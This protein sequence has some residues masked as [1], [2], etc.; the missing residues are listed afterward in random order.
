MRREQ[1]SDCFDPDTSALMRPPSVLT[2]RVALSVAGFA[3]ERSRRARIAKGDGARA[4]GFRGAWR[5]RRDIKGGHREEAGRVSVGVVG[6]SLVGMVQARCLG[7]SSVTVVVSLCLSL[8]LSLSRW[9][10]RG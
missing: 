4:R 1:K 9:I 10:R 8:S 7:R 6:R 5:Q 2:A 3:V